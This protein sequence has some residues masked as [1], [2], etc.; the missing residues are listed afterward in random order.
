YT[1]TAMVPRMGLQAKVSFVITDHDVEG[2]NFVPQSEMNVDGF[3]RVAN[4]GTK[5]SAGLSVQFAWPLPGESRPTPA[6]S[7]RTFPAH[8]VSWGLLGAARGS[9]GL[10]GDRPAVRRCELSELTY[11][12]KR[13]FSRFVADD[14]PDRSA[15]VRHGID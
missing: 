1:A 9:A 2:L 4:N 12:D 14:R 6:S 5:L 7:G 10:C 15:L 11:P 3:S 13:R 8:C